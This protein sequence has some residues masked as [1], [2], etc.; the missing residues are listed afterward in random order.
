[1]IGETL[2]TAGGKKPVATTSDAER[3]TRGTREDPRVLDGMPVRGPKRPHP[4]GTARV[5]RCRNEQRDC[6][7]CYRRGT[8]A[9][10]WAGKWRARV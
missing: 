6:C 5:Q 1:M 10:G 2:G 8:D 3:R 4:D 9:P 7:E